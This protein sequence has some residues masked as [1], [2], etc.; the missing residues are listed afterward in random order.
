VPCTYI[1]FAQ[2]PDFN[3]SSFAFPSKKKQT[4]GSLLPL[5]LPIHTRIHLKF[6]SERR[7]CSLIHVE[8]KQDPTKRGLFRYFCLSSST[9]SFVQ[10]IF[11][12]FFSKKIHKH[13]LESIDLIIAE[14][15][16]ILIES[17]VKTVVGIAQ[18][19]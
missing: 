5:F 12:I 6:P 10:S 8:N 18:K 2:Q 19:A 11:F 13:F 16:K 9:E 14:I 15:T 1:S 3:I 7:P 17:G 4:M